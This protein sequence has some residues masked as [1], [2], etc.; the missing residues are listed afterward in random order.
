MILTVEI[1]QWMMLLVMLLLQSS[2]AAMADS[3]LPQLGENAALNLQQEEA[4]GQGLFLKLKQRG[5]VVEDPL[6]SRYV[7]DIGESLLAKLDVRYRD[8]HFFLVKDDAINAFAAPGGYIGVNTGLI[9]VAENVDELAAVLAHEIGHVRLKHNMQM[10]EHA[11]K[12]N[13][14][15]MVSVLV[16]IQLSGQN[17]DAANAAL[18]TGIAGSSQSMINYTRENEY[19]ADRFGIE[20]LIKSDYNAQ[21]AVDFMRLLQRREQSG[22]LSGI[23]YL[24]THPL[25][26]NRIA[27]ITS[28]LQGVEKKAG[29]PLRFQQYMDY[30]FYLYPQSSEHRSSRFAQALDAMQNAD[31]LKAERLLREL[32]SIDPDSLWLNYALAENLQMQRKFDQA[33]ALY[34]DILLLY[35]EDLAIS[36]KLS[37]LL[38]QQNKYHQALAVIEPLAQKFKTSPA[39]YKVLVEVYSRLD[40]PLQKQ[41]AEA[42]FH[43]YNGNKDL[44]IKQFKA[45]LKRA[46][47]DVALAAEL[48]QKIEKK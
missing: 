39:V 42:N 46:D 45:L 30:L 2:L 34:R 27:E 20:L 4:L 16:A 38:L 43:W 41:L 24:H 48:S 29:S 7:Q 37:Q 28:R 17:T 21:A 22:E 31:Y 1:K 11:K 35:P 9:A 25:G 19:E 26:A 12:V 36:L 5:Y 44:A 32:L 23:E 33:K 13:I 18:F 47:I 10:I 14:A 15:S 3:E 40:R 6:L 8:Y